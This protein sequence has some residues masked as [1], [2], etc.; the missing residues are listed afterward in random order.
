MS[1]QIRWYDEA[2]VVVVGFGGAGAVAAIAAHDAGARV[3]ILEKQP[4]D[5][6]TETRHTPSTRMSAGRVLCPSNQEKTA[7][8][9]E[10]VVKIA[11]E[12]LDPERMEMISVFTKYL[13]DNSAWLEK[14]GI[15]VKIADSIRETRVDFPELPGSDEGSISSYPERVDKFRD[16]PPFLMD[17]QWLLLP[18][19]SLSCGRQQ[20]SPQRVLVAAESDPFAGEV[21]WSV[22]A[23]F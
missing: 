5:T 1:T 6:T 19:V 2:E 22:D 12:T 14:I 16:G 20:G 13:T 4:K 21:V 17:S 10:G 3:L 23:V 9:F 11:N 8:Y 15:K 18:G 7:L